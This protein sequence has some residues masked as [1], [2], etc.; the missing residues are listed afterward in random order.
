MPNEVRVFECFDCWHDATGRQASEESLRRHDFLR[1]PDPRLPN[2]LFSERTH[3]RGCSY[4]RPGSLATAHYRSPH[5]ANR[6]FDL[7]DDSVPIAPLVP[8]PEPRA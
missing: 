3:H 1:Q 6:S 5:P 4:C 8:A 2:L 7:H